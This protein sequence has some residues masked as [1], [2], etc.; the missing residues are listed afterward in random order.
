MSLLTNTNKPLVIYHANCSDGMAAAWAFWKH[1]KDDAEYYAA[2]YN[3]PA[4]DVFNREVYMLDFSYKRETMRNL[5]EFAK[6][7]LLLDHHKSAL[8]DLKG[9]ED[10]VDNFSQTYSTVENSGAMIAWK[11]VKQ[12]LK[13]IAYEPVSPLISYAEDRDL[14]KFNLPF[15]KEINQVIQIT[16]K[17]FY[18]FDKLADDLAVETFSVI[19]LGTTLLS[20]RNADIE[21]TIKQATRP[22]IIGGVEVMVVNT[23]PQLASETGNMLYERVKNLYQ[24][25]NTAFVATYSDGPEGR[26]FSLRSGKD[27]ADVSKIA[28]IYGGGGHPAAAGFSVPRDHELAKA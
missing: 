11:Y 18:K 28:G 4:P 2:S 6:S 25:P 10:E 5:C 24:E 8:E 19:E 14:W 15:S 12:V 17:D 21:K 20:I 1:F 13:G 16:E 7:I 26:F 3:R 23:L 9:L 22:M 27:G